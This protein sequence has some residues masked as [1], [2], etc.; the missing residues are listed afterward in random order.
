MPLYDPPLRHLVSHFEASL[1][2][3]HIS[4]LR[5][6]LHNLGARRAFVD[7]LQEGL[8]DVLIALSLSF[9]LLCRIRITKMP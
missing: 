5:V 7:V 4:V 3:C 9:D 6:K 8:E 2:L 1:A